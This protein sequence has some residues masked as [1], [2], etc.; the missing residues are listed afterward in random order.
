MD[1]WVDGRTDRRMGGRM[2]GRTDGWTDRW[3]DGWTGGRTD[4]RM[5]GWI[6]TLTPAEVLSCY[7]IRTV[8]ETAW[9]VPRPASGGLFPRA[10]RFSLLRIQTDY[11]T[12]AAAELP[13]PFQLAASR[14]LPP[15]S[16]YSETCPPSTTRQN[17]YSKHCPTKHGFQ[18]KRQKGFSY[19]PSLFPSAGFQPRIPLLL[20]VNSL[21]PTGTALLEPFQ[22]P[23]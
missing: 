15:R 14:L 22:F 17:S 5:D 8:L 12:L 20:A 6:R 19:S 21:Q 4:E 10:P 2:D 9:M 3:M 1:E 18:I 16:T 23:E 13:D 11:K 7:V